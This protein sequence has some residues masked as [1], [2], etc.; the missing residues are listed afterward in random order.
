M[1]SNLVS[2]HPYGCFQ[3]LGVLPQNGWW[4]SWKTLLKWMIWGYHYFR[5]HPYNSY[6]IPQRFVL[7]KPPWSLSVSRSLCLFVRWSSVV[8]GASDLDLHESST[9][10]LR[11]GWRDVPW[12]QVD[13]FKRE[14][15]SSS[16]YQF[17]GA[18]S[19]FF[20]GRCIPIENK[21][22]P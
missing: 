18:S 9:F 17:S 11:S 4:K 6:T 21:N 1:T 2:C 7:Q 16:K 3:K 10:H 8:R 12:F 14:A 15:G 20:G 5:K 19:L 13:H 22:S